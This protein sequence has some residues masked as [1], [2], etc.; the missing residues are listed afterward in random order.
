VAALIENSQAICSFRPAIEE[1]TAFDHDAPS[2][3]HFT[4]PG[5][6]DEIQPLEGQVSPFESLRRPWEIPGASQLAQF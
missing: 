6:D 5:I 3:P 2:T 4:W 1:G